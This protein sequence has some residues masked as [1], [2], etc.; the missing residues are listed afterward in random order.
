MCIA[1]LKRHR[2]CSLVLLRIALGAIFLVH[3]Y[4]KW[5]NF[6]ELPTLM[7]ILAIAEPLGGV[8]MLLGMLTRWAALGLAIIMIGAIWTKV[9]GSAG[10]SGFAGKGGWEFDA[11]ILAATF[12]LMTHG[13]GKWAL[14]I[15]TRWEKS[16]K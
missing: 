4:M 6:D 3:G 12:V 2:P 8:A 11:I 9:T 5:S 7:K 16:E 1:T 10:L 15:W 13:P 14:D